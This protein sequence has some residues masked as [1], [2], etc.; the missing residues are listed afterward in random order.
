MG[1]IRE[2]FKKKCYFCDKYDKEK[3]NHVHFLL[4]GLY[5][6]D[7]YFHHSC[8]KDILCN[9]EEHIDN[10]IY[11]AIDIQKSLIS[12]EKRRNEL[13]ATAKDLCIED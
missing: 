12:S 1:T 5:G 9:P 4:A 13:I 3:L 2:L 11:M 6:E 8:L 10:K 7:Y